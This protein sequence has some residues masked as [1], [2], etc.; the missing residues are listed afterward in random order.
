MADPTPK[1]IAVQHVHRAHER[2]LSREAILEEVA[3]SKAALSAIL[4]IIGLLLGGV[5]WAHNITITTTAKAEGEIVTT[6]ADRVVQHLEGGIVREILVKNGD[7]VEEGQILIR[8]DGTSR[9]S[10]LDQI[11]AR[12]ASLLVKEKRLRAQIDGSEPAFGELAQLHPQLVAEAISTLQ[13]NRDRIEGQ[14]AVIKSRIEQRQQ[15]VESFSDQAK[16]LEEQ[17]KILKETVDMRTKLF[18]SG[19]GTRIN[20]NTAKLEY[21]RVQSALSDARSSRDQ[22]LS[23]IEEAKNQ[24]K[25]LD[26]KEKDLAVE[27]LATVLPELAEVSESLKRLK[28]RVQ[29][30]DVTAPI[31]GIVN[32]LKVNTTGAVV[33]PA[34]VLLTIVPAEEKVLVEAHTDPADIGYLA[35][36]QEAKVTISGFDAR[37]HGMISGRLEQISPTSFTDAKGK[38]YFKTRITLDKNTI[39]TDTADHAITPGMT[40]QVQIITDKQSLLQYLTG[41]IYT[42]VVGAF[43]ER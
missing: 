33:E 18:E 6:G 42:S 32:G 17:V 38:P 25:E 24:L 30:L 1:P 2:Y 39:H 14:K 29:R 37:R 27:E 3:T 22:T 26:G 20:M 13:S 11:L 41:P 35:V 10:D 31:T 8:F 36:G 4:L 19:Y 9:T 23:S 40:V 16:R 5:V 7:R 12:E 34:Q 15:S 21:S 28:D 43:S